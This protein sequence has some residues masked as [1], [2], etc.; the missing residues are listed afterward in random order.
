MKTSLLFYPWS[1]VPLVVAMGCNDEVRRALDDMESRLKGSMKSLVDSEF[2]SLAQVAIVRELLSGKRTVTELVEA[3]YELKRGDE[4]FKTQYTRVMREVA[5][6]ES[7]GF[8][9]RRLFG[10]ER[11]YRLTQLAVARITKIAG[12]EPSWSPRL[13]RRADLVAYALALGTVVLSFL[14]ARDV[15]R[16]SDAFVRVLR[17]ISLFLGGLAFCRFLEL[18]RRVL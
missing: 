10:R 6:L 18:L 15:V 11:P 16:L 14:A 13:I 9:S 17:P 1:V 2:R 12:I 3:L 8:V 5:R 7:K 4:G